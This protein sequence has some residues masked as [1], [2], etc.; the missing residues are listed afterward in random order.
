VLRSSVC[1]A[2]KDHA[3]IRHTCEQSDALSS[4]TYTKHDGRYF[5]T[6]DI[7]DGKNNVKF[8]TSFLKTPDGHNWAVRIEGSAIDASE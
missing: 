6:Q 4:Y 2:L 5:S 3:E 8:V 1:L 7:V